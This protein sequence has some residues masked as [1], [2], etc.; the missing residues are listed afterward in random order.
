M[1]LPLQVI[2][3]VIFQICTVTSAAE[4]HQKIL[5]TKSST[6]LARIKCTFPSDCRYYIHWYQKKEGEALKRVQYVDIT[7]G[8]HD[9]DPGFDFLRSESPAK[10]TFVLII[11]DLKTEHSA[12]YYCACW[13]QGYTKVFGSGTTLYVTDNQV[14]APHVA[15]YPVSNQ[16]S[17]GKHALLCQ[18]SNMFPNLVRFTWR[19]KDQNGKIVKLPEKDDEVLEQKDEDQKVSITSILI[20]DQH[21]VGR[22]KFICSVE[23]DSSVND[24]SVNIPPGSSEL[25]RSRYLFSVSYV[26]L[27]VKNLLYFC[28]ISVLLCKRRSADK[29]TP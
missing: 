26:M 20:T 3:V 13:V 11:P 27:L 9:N 24:Q 28:T 25:S 23:H 19:K 8:K 18:A 4:L 1:H 21:K 15:G 10:D 2:L 22:N 16:H 29:K 12:T 6:K 17:K 14:K 7:G 5:M